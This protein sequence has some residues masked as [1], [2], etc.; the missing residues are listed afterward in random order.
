MIRHFCNGNCSPDERSDIRDRSP[1]VAALMRATHPCERAE[2]VVHSHLPPLTPACAGV[3][4][5]GV[6]N[7]GSGNR[8]LLLDSRVRGMSGVCGA[9]LAP[10]LTRHGRIYFGNPRLACST[11]SPDERSDIRD[12][13]PHVAALMRATRCGDALRIFLYMCRPHPC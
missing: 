11:C 6:S 13:S 5:P 2:C 12:H 9:R 7:Q 1:H 4:M 3:Q 8:R 10:T